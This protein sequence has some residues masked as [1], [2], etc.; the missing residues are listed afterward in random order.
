MRP[1]VFTET[2]WA[3]PFVVPLPGRTESHGETLVT[4]AMYETAGPV[5]VTFSGCEGGVEPPTVPL[6]VKLDGVGTVVT[7]KFTVTR[8]GLLVT[9]GAVEVSVIVP[10]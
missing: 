9:P 6:K 5:L 8:R 7:L 2:V 3:A 4:A 10:L 1:D